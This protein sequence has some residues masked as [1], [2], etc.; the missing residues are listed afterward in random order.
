MKNKIGRY[1]IISK[2]GK[3][4]LS[5]VYQAF[6]PILK[7]NVAL[8]VLKIMDPLL[9]ERFF[10]E[11]R[12]QASIEH[13]NICRI[14]DFGEIDGTPYIT[15]QFINGLPLQEAV[16]NMSLERKLIIIKKVA[17]ALHEAHK[18][19]LIH[20]DLKPSNIMVE[21]KDDGEDKPY[22]IDFGL[23][24]NIKESDSTLPG[25]IVGTLGYMAPEQIEGKTDEIDRRTDIYGIGA[26]LFAIITGEPPFKGETFE[27]LKEAIE[28][29][30]VPLR[31]LNKNVPKD[32]EAIVMKCLEKDYRRR[33]QTAGELSEDIGRFLNGEPIKAKSSGLFLTFLKR[34]KKNKIIWAVSSIAFI[35]IIFLITLLFYVQY[36]GRIQRNYSIEFEQQIKY[37]EDTLWYTYSMPLHD[38][39]G[40]IEAIKERLNYIERRVKQLGNK[41]CGP[42]FYALGRGY[43]ALHDYE[44]AKY[45]LELAWNE[46][47]YRVPIVSYFLSLSLIMLYDERDKKAD[48]IADVEIRTK[49]KNEIKKEYLERAMKFADA[50]REAQI[51]TWEYIDALKTFYDGRYLETL[52]KIN[53]LKKKFPWFYQAIKL[54]AEV[55]R[56]WGIE[57]MQQGEKEKALFNFDLSAKVLSDLSISSESDPEV[58]KALS[59]LELDFMELQIYHSSESVEEAFRKAAFYA[60]KAL[61]AKPQDKE[62]INLLSYAYWRGGS[63]LLYKGEDPREWL[64]KSTEYAKEAINLDPEDS[65]SYH[66]VATS[67]LELGAYLSSIGESPLKYFEDSIIFSKKALE[68]NPADVQSYNNIGLA[69]WNMGRWGLETG[70]DP[71]PYLKKGIE[72]LEQG[73]KI[74]PSFSSLYHTLGN[75][76][77]EKAIHARIQGLNALP[78]IKIAKEK[79]NQAISLKPNNFLSYNNLAECSILEAE[80]K[81]EKEL[82]PETELKMAREYLKKSLE[83]KQN[84]IWAYISGAK[85]ELIEAKWKIKKADD[86]QAAFSKAA[87]FIKKGETYAPF[88]IRLAELKAELYKI[89]AEWEIKTEKSPL[90]TLREGINEINKLLKKTS[91]S[92]AIF[93]ERGLLYL[94]TGKVEG[95]KE[96]YQKA[97]DDFKRGFSLSPFLEKEF[98][99]SLAEAERALSKILRSPLSPLGSENSGLSS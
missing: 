83:I 3:G 66:N 38:I 58:Y 67:S 2:V 36:K 48:K 84:F 59:G 27:S 53:S 32:V 17:D 93:I 47:N 1:E 20:R 41:A 71:Q 61:T 99:S 31:K 24:K 16:K 9:I 35:I 29:A 15:M 28:K 60:E 18:N 96:Y 5:I 52:E 50:G 11:A 43:F 97:I 42:G 98:S 14:Y 12:F 75:I 87:E 44:R 94:M 33:Y 19:G 54:E 34:A 69:C 79:F 23:V 64:Q 78:S 88:S 90:T 46:Y 76:Y 89:K 45:Y 68:F 25:V 82:S 21:T 26:L 7:R 49:I 56:R 13:E 65:F 81:R 6:D 51:E 92:G 74:N 91:G 86:P 73:I 30:P 37:L 62:A 4:G 80:G 70:H 8:K 63:Y 40:E 39:R 95:K 72:I 85:I 22:I 10:K 55:Y 77:L 57:S